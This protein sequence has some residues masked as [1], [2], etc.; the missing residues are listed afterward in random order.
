MNELEAGRALKPRK[1]GFL[2]QDEAI[3]FTHIP[4][5]GTRRLTVCQAAYCQQQ[6][7]AAGR[8]GLHT[9][10]PRQPPSGSGAQRK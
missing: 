6:K 1:S 10:K 5:T 7:L 9:R 3:H 2:A 8:G 4:R